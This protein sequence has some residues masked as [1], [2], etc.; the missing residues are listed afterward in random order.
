MPQAA[1]QQVLVVDS[2]VVVKWYL[3]DEEAVQAAL[4]LRSDFISGQ[5]SIVMP[6]LGR[7]EIANALNV[8]RRR[9]RISPD[10]AWRAVTDIFTWGFAFVGTD[11]IVLAAV[12]AARRFDCALYDA[13]YVALAE[14]LGCNFITADRALFIK[15]RAQVPWAM[16][17]D[18]YGR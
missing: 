13:A 6:D 17:L 16:L 10:E 5:F 15:T 11:D 7:Y 1:N 2:S 14:R 8:A 18:E 4:A 3:R 12:D 9:D